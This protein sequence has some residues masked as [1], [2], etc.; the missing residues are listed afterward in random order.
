MSRSPS[1]RLAARR[2]WLKKASIGAAVAASGLLSAPARS[3]EAPLRVVATFS[4]L[5][6]MARTIGGDAIE[7]ASLVQPDSDAHVFE[8]SP[9]DAQRLARAQLVIV[10]GLGFE[11]W[12]DRL[13]RAS[14]YRGPIVVASSG[15][16]PRQLGSHADPHAWQNLANGRLYADNITRAIAAAVPSKAT[17]IQARGLAY[18]KRIGE[19]DASARQRFGALPAGRRRVMTSHDAFGYFG[20][21][22][23]VRFVA[24]LSWN[25]DSEASAADVA[26]LIR[27]IRGDG[28]SALFVENITDPRLLQRIASE[29]GVAVGGTLFSD[30]LSKPGTQADTYLAMMSHNIDSLLDALAAKAR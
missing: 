19:L 13:V 9:A 23:G 30:A 25:T 15:V 2:Q 26:R 10:N 22:Y 17:A 28:A 29:S 18:A 3:A 7:A 5:A 27:Q 24:P 8:P 6:D 14:G 12:M 11:G 4:I 20:Q 21:A 16:E 1:P